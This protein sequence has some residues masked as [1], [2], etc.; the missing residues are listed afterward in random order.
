MG[1]L[2]FSD[3]AWLAMIGVSI[4]IGFIYY[5]AYSKIVITKFRLINYVIKSLLSALV[6]L[7][8]LVLLIKFGGL[9]GV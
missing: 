9:R 8:L 3:R 2:G 6:T 4:I 7:I 5:F 1:L